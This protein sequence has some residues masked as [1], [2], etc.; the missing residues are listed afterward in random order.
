[1]M[2]CFSWDFSFPDKTKHH[3]GGVGTIPTNMGVEAA[4][5]RVCDSVKN[6]FYGIMNVLSKPFSEVNTRQ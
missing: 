5:A 6:P 4:R 2:I 3:V 1:M